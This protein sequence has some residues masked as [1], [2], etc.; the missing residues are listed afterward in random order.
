MSM[1][2][3]LSTLFNDSKMA[4]SLSGIVLYFP[5]ALFFFLFCEHAIRLMENDFKP[6]T[7]YLTMGYFLP[8]FPFGVI[9]LRL[10]I[11]EKH[12]VI[13]DTSLP[14]AWFCLTISIPA[15]FMLFSYL[16]VIMPSNFGIRAP[17][18]F[19]LKKY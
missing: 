3:C 10:L 17:C 6:V 11:D 8:H 4:V 9:L 14:F 1:A 12:F 2:M 15:Y 13:L 16:D 19:C 5:I 18:C 7:F